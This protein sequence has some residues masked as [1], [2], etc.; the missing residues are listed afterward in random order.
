[1]FSASLHLPRWNYRFCA[2]Q[3]DV[4]GDPKCWNMH[5][6]VVAV[7]EFH[8]I[9]IEFLYNFMQSRYQHEYVD[10]SCYC[11]EVFSSRSAIANNS[12]LS[13]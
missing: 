5:G 12:L 8:S 13:L 11:S 4:G 2:I 7:V 6:I 10:R 1:M 3:H 9:Q